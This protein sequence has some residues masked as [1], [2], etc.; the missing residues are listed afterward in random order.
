MSKFYIYCRVATPRVT[1]PSHSLEGQKDALTSYAKQHGLVVS[2][3][4]V[5]SGSA[6]GYR[7]IFSQ[8][9]QG[10]E[11]GEADGIL[12]HDI[13]RLTRSSTDGQ[14]LTDMLDRGLIK[15]IQ[16]PALTLNKN[17][18]LWHLS[19]QKQEHD[20]LSQSIKRGLQMR[21]SRRNLR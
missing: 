16:T 7:P 18:L 4:F 5:E 2:Q 12:I 13:S 15:Q 1:H 6:M 21:Q 9:L 8:M 20:A 14:R 19:L 11:R 10:I 3:V 17:S